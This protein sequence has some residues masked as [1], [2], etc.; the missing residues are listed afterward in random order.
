LANRLGDGRA[1]PVIQIEQVAVQAVAVAAP[2]RQAQGRR[3]LRKGAHR[4]NP[5]FAEG[6]GDVSPGTERQGTWD[7]REQPPRPCNCRREASVL[8]RRR[9]SSRARRS[10]GRRSRV[11]RARGWG[12]GKPGTSR[13]GPAGVGEE[14]SRGG[15]AHAWG[16]TAAT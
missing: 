5:P 9:P 16:N 2:G 13:A 8:R 14:V 15:S 7:G 12:R 4:K 10:A 1:Q 6:D 11:A 3:P